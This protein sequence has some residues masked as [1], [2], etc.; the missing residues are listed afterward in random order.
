VRKS[1]LTRRKFTLVDAAGIRKKSTSNPRPRFKPA[2]GRQAA[3]LGHRR[4]FTVVDAA[5]HL[6]LLLRLLVFHCR[7]ASLQ[8]RGEISIKFAHLV[9]NLIAQTAK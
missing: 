3:N 6:R 5:G 4:K 1:Q 8:F 7:R 2:C 9:G